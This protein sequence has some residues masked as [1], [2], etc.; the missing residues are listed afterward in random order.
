VAMIAYAMVQE[1]ATA[2][3][4]RNLRYKRASKN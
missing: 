1:W 3:N 4:Y 2:L